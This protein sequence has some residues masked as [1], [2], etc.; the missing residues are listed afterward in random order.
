[1]VGTFFDTMSIVK[2]RLTL[3]LQSLTQLRKTS[4]YFHSVLEAS[5]AE[6]GQLIAGINF[7]SFL[8]PDMASKNDARHGIGLS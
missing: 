1:M 4:L 5:F 6:V 8:T 7:V 2:S 3:Y